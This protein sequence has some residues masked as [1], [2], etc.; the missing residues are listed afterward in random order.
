M[1]ATTGL[2]ALYSDARKRAPGLSATPPDSTRRPP[3]SRAGHREFD[4]R[5]LPCKVRNRSVP[6]ASGG[7]GGEWVAAGVGGDEFAQVGE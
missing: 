4:G 7:E 2:K 3:A 1:P 6:G 5:E